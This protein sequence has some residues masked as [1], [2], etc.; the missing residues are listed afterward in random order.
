[1]ME[2]KPNL[3]VLQLLHS[4]TSEPA[5]GNQKPYRRHSARD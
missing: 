1:M 5:A 3:V 4:A 2:L